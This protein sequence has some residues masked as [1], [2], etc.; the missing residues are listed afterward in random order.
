MCTHTL[1]HTLPTQRHTHARTPRSFRNAVRQQSL[2]SQRAHLFAWLF[3][4]QAHFWAQHMCIWHFLL[5]YSHSL[6][7]LGAISPSAFSRWQV[8]LK[9]SD[10]RH[11][12][13]FMAVG[14]GQGEHLR[15]VLLLCFVVFP[16]LPLLRLWVRGFSARVYPYMLCDMV[17]KCLMTPVPHGT[18][19]I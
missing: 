6:L 19:T 5:F 15:C 18:P 1:M 7:H 4:S 8:S 11:C 17:K 13:S 9:R 10:L 14:K 2:W 3:R 16:V 12:P